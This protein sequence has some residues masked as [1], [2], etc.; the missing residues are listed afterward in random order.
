ML[1][2]ISKAQRVLV[3][4]GDPR[5]LAKLDEQLGNNGTAIDKAESVSAGSRLISSGIYDLAIM[6]LGCREDCALVRLAVSKGIP[7]VVMA[8][9]QT[10][11]AAMMEAA[12]SGARACL[13]TGLLGRGDPFGECLITL[14]SLLS[15]DWVQRI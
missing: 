4:D 14:Q 15:R 5:I 11:P 2:K 7:V 6:N 10:S 8:A 3:V 9:Y 13:L 1:T 12:R